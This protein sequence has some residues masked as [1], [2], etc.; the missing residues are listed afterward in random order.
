MQW[1]VSIVVVLALVGV[2]NGIRIY[3]DRKIVERVYFARGYLLVKIDIADST[4][5]K[6]FIPRGL[7]RSL[8]HENRTFKVSIEGYD[9]GLLKIIN[10]K[11]IKYIE[12]LKPPEFSTKGG[13]FSRLSK[14]I[15]N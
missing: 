8:K 4:S 6:G 9:T 5:C 13:W 7:Y 14:K 1:I 15:L 11:D 10:S 3:K 2:I 12:V